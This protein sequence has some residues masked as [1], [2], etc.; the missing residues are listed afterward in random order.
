MGTVL[1]SEE[2]ISGK[3]GRN[4]LR[5]YRTFKS[6][7]EFESYLDNVSNT[8]HRKMMA[9]LQTS[10]HTLMCEMGRHYDLPYAAR[11]CQI[12]N[13]GDVESE[14]HVMSKCSEYKSLRDE[15]HIRVNNWLRNAVPEQLVTEQHILKSDNPD[16]QKT[17]AKYIFDAFNSREN[18]MGN[19][20]I[21]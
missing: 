15:L 11:L 19:K 5:F 6:H 2:T 12:C 18:Q 20:S 16:V 9:K 13:S 7:F 21:P 4:K 10:S 1:T 14:E 3:V 17:L 8:E